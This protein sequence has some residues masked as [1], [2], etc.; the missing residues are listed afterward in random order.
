MNDFTKEEL[1]EVWVVCC[2]PPEMGGQLLLEWIE[3]YS[4]ESRFKPDENESF[5][6][7]KSAIDAVIRRLEQ[8]RDE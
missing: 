1:Y 7:K 6:S 3:V 5:S 2:C 4:Y 8:L